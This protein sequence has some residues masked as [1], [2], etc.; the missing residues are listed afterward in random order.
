MERKAAP[1]IAGLKAFARTYAGWAFSQTFYREAMYNQIGFKTIEELLVDWENDHIK[2]W[3]ANDLL[4]KLAT[5]QAIDI[6]DGSQYEGNII[7]ALQSIKARA[8]LMPCTQ[9]LYF[10]PEDNFLEARHIPNVEIL[11]Y[12]SPWGHC[13]GNPGNDRGFENMLDKY[14][15]KLLK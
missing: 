2:N 9:D 10:P 3:D 12:D 1:P 13:V 8:I 7:K 5:W 15:C 6:S 4:A 14:I 11:P